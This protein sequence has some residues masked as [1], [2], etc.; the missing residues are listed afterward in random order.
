MSFFAAMLT[1]VVNDLPYA[2]LFPWPLFLP[3][4]GVLLARRRGLEQR[5][6]GL[7]GLPFWR[8]LAGDALL[9]LLAGFLSSLLLL[10]LGLPL[11]PDDFAYILPVA[12]LLM[13]LD[14]RYLCL[15]YAGGILSLL[16]LIFRWPSIHLPNLLALVAALHLTESIM[17]AVDGHERA[18]PAYFRLRNRGTVGGYLLQRVWPMPLLYLSVATGALPPGGVQYLKPPSWWPLI[19]LAAEHVG[20]QIV[21][22]ALPAA[23][24]LG[25]GDLALSRT[26]R[27]KS[28]R[29]AGFLALYGL[30]LLGLAVAA[31]HQPGLAWAAAV[32]APCGHEAVLYFARRS[33]IHGKPFFFPRPEGVPIL[34]VLPGSPADRMGLT[35]GMIVT[36]INDHPVKTK[37]E[38]VTGLTEMPFFVTITAVSP[39]GAL[40]KNYEFRS[41]TSRLG[42][43][44]APAPEE[45][46][47]VD[48]APWR[49]FPVRRRKR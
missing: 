43:L 25:Y 20:K 31:A 16:H 39:G 22:F 42:I 19:P 5:L 18:L 37:A 40:E 35:P 11:Y 45:P 33:E 6:L 36:K 32:F 14:M 3:V 48:V 12:L 27:A 24:I 21:F 7:S 26:P 46:A 8:E 4:V 28:L 34:A 44:F 49:F 30:V 2:I 10:Y 9:G 47:H 38:A 13:L 17:I 1:R 41:E 29:T 15:A 23:V